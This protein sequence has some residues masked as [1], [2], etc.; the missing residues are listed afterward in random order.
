MN[1]PE[2]FFEQQDKLGICSDA[3]IKFVEKS[4]EVQTTQDFINLIN[5]SLQPIFP[6]GM[7]LAGIG[8]I[9]PNGIAVQH[10][11]GI[12]Y[13]KYYL[14]KLQ[15]R[16]IL[17]GPILGQWL[18]TH[19]PQLFEVRQPQDPIPKRWLNAVRL[20]NIQNIAAHG[21]HDVS[22]QGASYFTFSRIPGSL[23]TQH[24][25]VLAM[26]IP[27]LHSALRRAGVAARKQEMINGHNA[28]YLLTPREQ[29]IMYL[30][31]QGKSD[32][33]IAKTINRSVYTVHN[34]VKNILAKLGVEN[35]THA[36]SM[37]SNMTFKFAVNDLG[38]TNSSWPLC[39][40]QHNG[41]SSR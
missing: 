10:A 34:H 8:R 41:P 30:L 36:V 16:P 13:P 35:R 37:A 33:V 6:H 23:G 3:F 14:A 31:K 9:Q 4:L 38:S 18:E 11:I 20:A 17:A 21:I 24:R 15:S 25:R 12:N 1:A 7:M 39:G 29:E 27:P 28:N 19:E 2:R 40:A 26:I 5:H 32:A 22:G